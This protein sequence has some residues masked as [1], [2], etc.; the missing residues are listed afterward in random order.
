[1]SGTALP[2][3]HFNPRAGFA[4]STRTLRAMHASTGRRVTIAGKRNRNIQQIERKSPDIEPI[5][6]RTFAL[7]NSCF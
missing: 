5:N 7:Y 6:I 3:L 4:E 2:K 1:M